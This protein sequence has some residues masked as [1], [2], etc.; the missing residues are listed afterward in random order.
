MDILPKC[1]GYK[2]FTKLDISMQYNTFELDEYSQELSTIITLYWKYKYLRLPMGLKCFPVIAQ[3]IMESELAGIDDAGVYIHDV[4]AF[5]HTWDDHIKLLGNILQHISEHGF[6]INPHKCQWAI[7]ETDR[8]GYW[9]PP[10]GLKAWK[11]KIDAILHMDR[12]QNATEL[13]MV[14]GCVNYYRDMWP[15]HT[16]IL[17]SLTDHSGLKKHGPIPWTLDMH[18]TFN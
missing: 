9:L 6:P 10:R 16:H 3:S 12:P 1:S 14:I 4:G 17:K 13:C 7:K 2:F 18:T 15:S 11:K 5:L 8:L